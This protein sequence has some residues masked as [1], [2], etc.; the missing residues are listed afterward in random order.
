MTSIGFIVIWWKWVLL[1]YIIWILWDIKELTFTL[2]REKRK[3][4]KKKRISPIRNRRV[5]T[6][7]GVL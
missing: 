3:R 1:G 6:Q 4:K 7:K 5:T 2:M